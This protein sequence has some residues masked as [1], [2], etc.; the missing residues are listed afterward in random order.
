MYTTNVLVCVVTVL[1]GLFFRK[2]QYTKNRCKQ[3]QEVVVVVVGGIIV[4]SSIRF[5]D[6]IEF[7][8]EIN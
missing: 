8:I 4:G 7:E 6:Q 3:K 5:H 2:G 1:Q